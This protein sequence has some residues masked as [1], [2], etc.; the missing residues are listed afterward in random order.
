MKNISIEP[1]DANKY[2]TG[3]G[4]DKLLHDMEALPMSDVIKIAGPETA[5]SL[6]RMAA[7]FVLQ[8]HVSND[9]YLKELYWLAITDLIN[10]AS[11]EY[12]YA[13]HWA[14]YRAETYRKTN[15]T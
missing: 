14:I 1:E 15:K 4:I 8:S 12:R 6:K 10:D 11:G 13:I 5:D 7:A 9:K 3:P 2:A